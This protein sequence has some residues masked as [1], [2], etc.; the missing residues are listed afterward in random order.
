M[1]EISAAILNR[2]N[3]VAHRSWIIYCGKSNVHKNNKMTRNVKE[4]VYNFQTTL[5]PTTADA[6]TGTY[7][8]LVWVAQA[9]LITGN[10]DSKDWSTTPSV[11][12]NVHREPIYVAFRWNILW[13][14]RSVLWRPSGPVHGLWTDTFGVFG[15]CH[16]PHRCYVSVL[17]ILKLCDFC[18][19]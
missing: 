16:D 4:S 19:K 8:A 2:Q 5:N 18:F 3:L 6:G 14:I 9:R 15:Y 7:M 17:Y 12:G 1:Y 10:T 13:H 11:G